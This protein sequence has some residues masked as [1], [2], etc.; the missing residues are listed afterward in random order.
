ME[1]FKD[2]P[3]VQI[4]NMVNSTSQNFVAAM[5]NYIES[6]EFRDGTFVGWE[7]LFLKYWRRK[8]LKDAAGRNRDII[9][10]GEGREY[11]QAW[12]YMPMND[13][14]ILCSEEGN[15]ES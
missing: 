14:G 1:H 5:R 6:D 3:V 13:E 8:V 15:C 12:R 4:P 7:R 10:D 11:Y 9:I 2:L